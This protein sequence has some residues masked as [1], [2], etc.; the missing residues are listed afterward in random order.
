MD[1]GQTS[2]SP[3]TPGVEENFTNGPAKIL[4]VDDDQAMRTLLSILFIRAGFD[5]AEA[6]NGFEGLQLLCH[7]YFDLVV[8]DGAMPV[9][10][11]LTM[12]SEA[13]ALAPKARFIVHSGSDRE[14]L[15]RAR[16]L[17]AGSILAVLSK[18]APSSA[19]VAAVKDALRACRCHCQ[20]GEGASTQSRSTSTYVNPLFGAVREKLST[21]VHFRQ[22]LC[23][24]VL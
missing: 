9:K 3:T 20:D 23:G 2:Q 13:R 1:L 15:E 14:T 22:D 8:T 6:S 7:E 16:E 17:S 24:S 21:K 10:D 19:I 4:V 18:P 5:V 11:G 12:I